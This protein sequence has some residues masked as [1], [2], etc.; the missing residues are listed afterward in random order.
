MGTL[1]WLGLGILVYLVLEEVSK[2]DLF[3]TLTEATGGTG[4]VT[5]TGAGNNPPPTGGSGGTGAGTGAGTGTGSGTG[6][7]AA[8]CQ[9]VAFTCPDGTVLHQT[10]TGADCAVGPWTCPDDTKTQTGNAAT[11]SQLTMLLNQQAVKD[12]VPASNVVGGQVVY[13]I[14]QWNYVF[15]EIMP[16]AQPLD[17]RGNPVAMPFANNRMGAGE[18]ILLRTQGGVGLSGVMPMGYAPRGM[19]ALATVEMRKAGGSKWTM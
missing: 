13:T 14:D 15:H 11:A 12:G 6:S 18:Y 4:T 7:G 1:K 8:T 9:P 19:A 5:G 16:N 17:P 2:G 10:G 3:G